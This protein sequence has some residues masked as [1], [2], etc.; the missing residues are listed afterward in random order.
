MTPK[1][2]QLYEAACQ[3]LG[4][5]KVRMDQRK[6]AYELARTEYEA[7]RRAVAQM[8]R[9]LLTKKKERIK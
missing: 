9:A 1:K 6:G 8:E 2:H 5:L 3:D 7:Q 4:E